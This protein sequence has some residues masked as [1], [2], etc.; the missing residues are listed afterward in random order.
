MSVLSDEL[1]A[2]VRAEVVADPA[3]AEKGMFGGVGYLIN[4]NM[5]AGAT[6]KGLLMVRL[7]TE[8]VALA[9]NLPGAGQVDF[10]APRRG[11]FLMLPAEVTA[12]NA[13]AAWYGFALEQ[14]KTLPAK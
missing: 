14:G 10:E 1:A 6:S 5:F 3:V 7:R 4:G 9:R 2:R 12:G 8:D 13:L 11:G